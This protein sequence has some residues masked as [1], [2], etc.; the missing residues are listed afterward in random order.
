[1]PGISND[2]STRLLDS[3]TKL[4]DIYTNN[5]LTLVSSDTPSTQQFGDLQAMYNRLKQK[6]DTKQ[7]TID[8]YDRE[9][10]D[11]RSS[12]QPYTFWRLRGVSTLQDWVL[13][14]F[15]IIYGLICFS[16]LMLTLTS[17]Y[18]LYLFSVVLLTSL[19]IGIMIVATIVRFA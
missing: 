11:R 8:T 14:V 1:M 6:Y 4:N 2:V 15:F 13:L 7:D 16:I 12:E 5:Y 19:T 10:L 9:Y 3:L 18:P 17:P